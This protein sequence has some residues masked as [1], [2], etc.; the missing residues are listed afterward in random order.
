[1]HRKTRTR[2]TGRRLAGIIIADVLFL[3]FTIYAGW[4]LSFDVFIWFTGGELAG[5]L[6][7][8]TVA[9]FCTP[10]GITKKEDTE[11]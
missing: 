2:L 11:S 4:H 7:T 1:M 3:A 9:H 10:T 6:V 5:M 8:L